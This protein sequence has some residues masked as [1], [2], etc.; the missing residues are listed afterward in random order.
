MSFR[1]NGLKKTTI[2]L[3]G[4]QYMRLHAM[5]LEKALDARGGRTDVSLIIRNIIDTYLEAFDEASPKPKRVRKS[6]RSAK[7]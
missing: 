4:D 1:P 5:G 3:R 7:T 2:Y 6:V